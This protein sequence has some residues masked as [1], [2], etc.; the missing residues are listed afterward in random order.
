MSQPGRADSYFGL[1]GLADPAISRISDGFAP[2]LSAILP[3]ARDE[4]GLAFPSKLY[5]DASGARLRIG[6]N[7]EGAPVAIAPSFLGAGSMLGR[8]VGFAPRPTDSFIEA[9][10]YFQIMDRGEDAFPLVAALSDPQKIAQ[11]TEN[12]VGF[13]Q[14]TLLPH[15]FDLFA[16]PQTFMEYQRQAAPDRP[17]FAPRAVIPTGVFEPDGKPSQP[18]A[19]VIGEIIDVRELTVALT[20]RAIVAL[21]LATFAGTLSVVANREAFAGLP[22][23]GN[24]LRA[25]GFVM[26]QFE[27]L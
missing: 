27:P 7:G 22:K 20:G 18:A 24:T 2:M 15:E 11:W 9:Q 3:R 5:T 12:C 1:I 4:H 13:L 17:P 19:M 21:E 8:L 26:A 6:M 14:V 25:F 23:G 16:S 10:G